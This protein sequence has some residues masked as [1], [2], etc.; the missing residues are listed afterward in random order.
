MP[1]KK[2]PRIQSPFLRLFLAFYG[3][4][5]LY[6]AVP[7]ET[8]KTPKSSYFPSLRQLYHLSLVF[9]FNWVCQ[10]PDSLHEQFMTEAEY[11]GKPLAQLSYRLF[12]IAYRALFALNVLYCLRFGPE[13]VTILDRLHSF[14]SENPEKKRS[15]FIFAALLLL[16]HAFF[17]VAYQESLY[18]ALKSYSTPSFAWSL[19]SLLTQYLHTQKYVS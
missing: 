3:N 11:F 17:Y 18:L 19:L 12:D 2:T 16:D 5:S 8:S 14:S 6:L 7:A 4:F 13:V 1:T 10:L 15:K 9:F